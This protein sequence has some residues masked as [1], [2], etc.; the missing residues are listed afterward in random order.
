MVFVVALL[1]TP[2]N[3]R[4]PSLEPPIY[5][6]DLPP[7]Q[8]LQE[9]ILAPLDK[10]LEED[11]ASGVVSAGPGVHACWLEMTQLGSFVCGS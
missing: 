1:E 2:L 8:P 7:E 3:L 10:V 6:T 11:S 9:R 4:V 5:P